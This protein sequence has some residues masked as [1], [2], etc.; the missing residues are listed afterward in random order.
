MDLDKSWRLTITYNHKENSIR[1]EE[2]TNH[3]DD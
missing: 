3:Y 2:V 1:I